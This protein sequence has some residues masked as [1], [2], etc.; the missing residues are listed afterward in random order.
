M[1]GHKVNA[2]NVERNKLTLE[3]SE[4]AVEVAARTQDKLAQTFEEQDVVLSGLSD[5]EDDDDGS[6][7]FA[8]KDSSLDET[9]DAD[10]DETQAKL[11]DLDKSAKNLENWLELKV[12]PV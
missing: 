1:F 7:L 10:L 9:E 3:L 6:K 12:S 11:D 5:D 4:T 8:P 2:D